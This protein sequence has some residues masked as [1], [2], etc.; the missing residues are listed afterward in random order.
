MCDSI[1]HVSVV[2]KNDTSDLE[3]RLISF[4]IPVRN[5]KAQKIRHA[6]ELKSELREPRH[7]IEVLHYNILKDIP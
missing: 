7:E 3:S 1:S 2:R 5:A 6:K 4:P